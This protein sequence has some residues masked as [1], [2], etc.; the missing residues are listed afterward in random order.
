MSQAVIGHMIHE[1]MA[2]DAL[3][4]QAPVHIGEYRKHRFDFAALNQVAELCAG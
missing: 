2:G 1:E 3:P 4:H